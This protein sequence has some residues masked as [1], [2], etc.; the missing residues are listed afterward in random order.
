MGRRKGKERAAAGGK[1]VKMSS[2]KTPARVVTISGQIASG[3]S[4][5]AEAIASATGWPV[6]SF[7]V[8]VRSVAARRG[9]GTDRATLQAVGSE[10]VRGGEERFVAEVLRAAGWRPG[11]PAVLEGVRHLSVLNAVRRVT[12]PVPVFHV[13]VAVGEDERGTRV[14]LRESDRRIQLMDAHETER[15]A[16]SGAALEHA[17]DCVADGAADPVVQAIYII[18][19]FYI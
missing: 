14:A 3:K 6:A 17:A 9:L 19:C 12:T 11:Q 16:Q 8:Y 5:L 7:G 2:A 10:L 15:D 4:T 1:P 13:H 18:K